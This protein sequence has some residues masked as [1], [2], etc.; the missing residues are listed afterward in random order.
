MLN[1]SNPNVL[2]STMFIRDNIEILRG[3]DNEC[4]DLIYRNST[5]G[6]RDMSYLTALWSSYN[7]IS[8]VSNRL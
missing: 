4:I 1:K 6:D 3:I 8:T 7:V 5:K 2:P